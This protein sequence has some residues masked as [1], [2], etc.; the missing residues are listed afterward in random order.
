MFSLKKK[1]TLRIS[2]R[3]KNVYAEM[4]LS[5]YYQLNEKILYNSL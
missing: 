2:W 3:Q 4:T 5:I 1:K